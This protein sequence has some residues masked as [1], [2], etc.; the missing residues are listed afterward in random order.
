MQGAEGEGCWTEGGGAGQWIVLCE[1]SV[2]PDH[3]GT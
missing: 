1:H 3:S 2:A